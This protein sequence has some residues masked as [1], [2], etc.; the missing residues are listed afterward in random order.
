MSVRKEA[1]VDGARHD[2]CFN[3]SV[4]LVENPVRFVLHIHHHDNRGKQAIRLKTGVDE[5]VR[6]FSPTAKS[7]GVL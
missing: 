4:V 2:I 5:W 3:W 6:D 7:Q 1:L